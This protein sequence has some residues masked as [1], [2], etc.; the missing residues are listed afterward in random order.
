MGSVPFAVTTSELPFLVQGQGPISYEGTLEQ[1]WGTY[2]VTMDLDADAIL[3]SAKAGGPLTRPADGHGQTTVLKS[4]AMVPS[5]NA[6]DREP[7]VPVD[8]LRLALFCCTL[9]RI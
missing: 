4:K 9:V 1:E 3:E 2:V 7:H 6:L 5:T 8:P